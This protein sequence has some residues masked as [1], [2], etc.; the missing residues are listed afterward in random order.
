MFQVLRTLLV[1]T[2]QDLAQGLQIF[3]FAGHDGVSDRFRRRGLDFSSVY[4]CLNAI[5]Y[6]WSVCVAG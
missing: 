6:D 2:Q 3:I 1:M 4:A 5:V